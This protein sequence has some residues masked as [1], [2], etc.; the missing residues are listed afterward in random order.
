MARADSPKRSI[1]ALRIRSR[2]AVHQDH[3]RHGRFPVGRRPRARYSAGIRGVPGRLPGFA[4]VGQRV[5][6]W[7]MAAI[8]VD[9]RRRN[10]AVTLRRHEA[11]QAKQ[12]GCCCRSQLRCEEGLCA[13]PLAEASIKPRLLV[14]A[15]LATYMF[16]VIPVFSDLSGQRSCAIPPPYKQRSRAWLFPG[17]NSTGE[18]RRVPW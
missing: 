15:G 12:A 11:Q 4:R 8:R 5:H 18:G 14:P 1:I 13:E 16:Q 17:H 2:T 7:R 3:Q 9:W 6:P 10:A